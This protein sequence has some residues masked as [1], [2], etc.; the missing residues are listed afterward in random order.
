MIYKDYSFSQVFWA[1]PIENSAVIKQDAPIRRVVYW[2]TAKRVHH[3]Q[4]ARLCIQ[5]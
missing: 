5:M 2:T 1:D 4:L 3:A